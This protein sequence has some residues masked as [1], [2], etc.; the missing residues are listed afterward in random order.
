[1]TANA[2]AAALIAANP[3]PAAHLALL[4]TVVIIGL[5]VFAVAR[6]RNKREAAEAEELS[7]HEPDEHPGAGHDHR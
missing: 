2:L 7:Q 4:G 3:G 6:L 5:I 1:V